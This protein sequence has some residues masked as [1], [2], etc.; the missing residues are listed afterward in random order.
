MADFRH[1]K[2]FRGASFEDADL[3]GATFRDCDMSGL[4]IVDTFLT[5][6]NI[7]GLIRNVRVNDVDVTAYV[8]GGLD[9][10]FPERAQARSLRTVDELRAMWDVIERLWAGTT[11]RVE[12]LPEARRDERVDDEWSFMETQRHLIFCTDAW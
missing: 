9:R 5:D 1:T 6:V 4:K 7:S 2:E 3:S 8:E 11:E 10:Q 12:R